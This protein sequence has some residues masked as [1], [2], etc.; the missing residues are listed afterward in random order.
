MPA[1]RTSAADALHKAT[2]GSRGAVR[3]GRGRGPERRRDDPQPRLARAISDQGF[4]QARRMLELQDHL[5]RRQARQSPT[6]GI[7]PVKTCSGCGTVKAKLALSERTYQCEACGLVLDRD[8]N[9]AVNLLTL[10]ASG[11]ERHKR[12]RRDCKTRP[13]RARPGETGT[14]HR[15]RG[16]DRDR[17]R[18]TAGCDGGCPL[19]HPQS[20][21]YRSHSDAL[22]RRPQLPRHALRLRDRPARP[23]RRGEAGPGSHSDLGRRRLAGAPVHAAGTTVRRHHSAVFRYRP[24]AGTRR[25][26]SGSSVADRAGLARHLRHDR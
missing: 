21:R 11:A 22:G 2:S 16:Q 4:G 14:R 23:V 9:A 7:R 1:S 10:A 20:Q 3:D 24:G 6:A 19:M 8:V 17:Q 5:E 18:A 13:A 15:A 12:L 26:R 25:R